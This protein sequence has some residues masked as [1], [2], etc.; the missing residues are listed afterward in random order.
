MDTWVSLTALKILKVFNLPH[1][2]LYDGEIEVLLY[3]IGFETAFQ[4]SDSKNNK[5][6]Y[7]A[8]MYF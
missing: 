4:R 3:R 2:L 1:I 7:C 6:S 8:Q 5:Q